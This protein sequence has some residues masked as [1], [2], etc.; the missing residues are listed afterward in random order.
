M[1]QSE[2]AAAFGVPCTK[3]KVYNWEKGR[4]LPP[5][6]EYN[7]R[8]VSY[9]ADLRL[10]LTAKNKLILAAIIDEYKSRQAVRQGAKDVKF[11]HFKSEE[12]L[13]TMRE[14]RG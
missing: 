3:T 9:H 14:K 11:V 5:S 7:G 8:M 12:S 2:M 1:S 13:A 10:H 6:A 4:T